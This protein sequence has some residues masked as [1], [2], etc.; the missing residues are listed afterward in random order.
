MLQYAK[1][2]TIAKEF[3]IGEKT[4]RSWIKKGLIIAS[5]PDTGPTLVNVQ[6]VGKYLTG[7]RVNHPETDTIVSD[8]LSQI[9]A[10]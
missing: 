6:S 7:C 8:I 1:V 2:K 4:V 3:D 5:K 9:S 10:N